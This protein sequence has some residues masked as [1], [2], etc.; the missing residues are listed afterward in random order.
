[1]SFCFFCVIGCSF[2]YASKI[3]K[4]E[5]LQREGY[6]IAQGIL[7]FGVQILLFACA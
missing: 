4:V 7:G 3:F 2:D 5:K 1:M 6:R